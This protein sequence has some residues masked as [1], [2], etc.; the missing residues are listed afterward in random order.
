MFVLKEVIKEPMKYRLSLRN[1]P[2]VNLLLVDINGKVSW[3]Y[4]IF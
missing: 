2:L 3:I 1:I 4:K